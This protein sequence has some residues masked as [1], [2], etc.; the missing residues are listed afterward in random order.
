VVVIAYLCEVVYGGL[1]HGL[2]ARAVLH[3]LPAQHTQGTSPSLAEQGG[4]DQWRVAPLSERR[5]TSLKCV[6][7]WSCIFA[8][9]VLDV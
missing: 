4:R 5:G 1:D 3:Q 7:V 2:L 9:P 8:H 6:Y